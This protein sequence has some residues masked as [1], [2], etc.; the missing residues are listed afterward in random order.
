MCKRIPF[1]RIFLAALLGIFLDANYQPSLPVWIIVLSFFFSSTICFFKSTLIIQWKWGWILGSSMIGIL[2][3]IGGI[4]NALR[5]N[6]RKV[7]P[8]LDTSA[9]LLSITEGPKQGSAS[10]RYLAR[11]YKADQPM[12]NPI[13]KTYVYIK[14]TDS[15][16]FIPGDVLLSMTLPQPLKNNANPGSFDFFT[17]S[18]RNG[19]GFTMML[20]HPSQYIKISASAPGS[21]DWTYIVREKILAIIKQHIKNK[22]NAGLAEAMLI[23]Y[24]EDLDKELLNAY[25]N[26]GVVHIIAISGLH[27]GLIFML[28]DLLIRSVA[29]RKKA[30]WAGLFI[31]LPLLWSFAILTGSSASVIR[32]AIMFSFIIIGNA[33]GRKSNG[34]NSLLGSACM[35]LLWNP[36]LRF[37]LGFQLSYAA[38][39]SI[40]L[41]D[42]EIKKMV[43]F[44]NKSA[45]Y[46]WSMVSITLAAQV[47]TTP[48]VIA[49]FHRFPTLFLFTN[50]VAVPLS[51]VVL[52]MEIA[53]CIVHPFDA[54]A[55]GLG[56][57]INILIQL[58]NDH[59]L[60]MGNIPFGMIDQLHV[61]NTMMFLIC[62]YAAA[63]YFLFT[64]PDRLI[65]QC[66]AL[67]GLALPVV[68]LIESIQTSKK[69]EIHVLNTYGATTIV[70]RH[71]QYATLTASA[72]LLDNKKK[73]KELLRQTGLALGIEHWTIQSFPNDPVMINLQEAQQTKPWVLLCHAKSI[74]LNNLKDEISKETLMLADASTPVWKIKQWEKEA[75]KLHLRFKPIPEE[76][77][78]T[79]RCH[80]TQ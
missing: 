70:H 61:S 29:G 56:A 60:L 71:G 55:T 17:Y 23:G 52:I 25:T 76:G 15:S 62:F 46:L 73:T 41:F 50:L 12:P 38:V 28:M 67:L 9:V 72:S 78:Y 33:I 45:L 48:I 66:L 6:S 68:H 53:L 80:Q 32:S 3:A 36:D 74:S 16:T 58:M 35:L 40:L 14:K 19:I 64:S 44:K 37:D 22:Q 27:L 79:I 10:N 49:N 69:K 18:K 11:V 7:Y 42:Q 63:W 21:K 26:T 2:I 65:Y 13:L 8:A 20:E 75:Q 31:S 39:A 34:M 57:A 5:S 54:I 47:L 77:P 4:S 43:F 30:T 24:R 51:S 59:V 1:F